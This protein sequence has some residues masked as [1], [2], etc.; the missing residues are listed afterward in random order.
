M[1]VCAKMGLC[2][3]SAHVMDAWGSHQQQ[4]VQVARRL[5]AQS[6]SKADL[7][8]KHSWAGT[9]S[10]LRT[11]WRWALSILGSTC[12]KRPPQLES[13]ECSSTRPWARA[14]LEAGSACI[15]DLQS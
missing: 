10:S 13:R 11:L 3:A 1:Q 4:A 6:S 8:G 9:K 14:D 15:A 7:L 2:E 5:L 12:C